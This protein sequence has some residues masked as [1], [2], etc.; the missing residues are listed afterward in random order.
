VTTL[1]PDPTEEQRTRWR[2]KYRRQMDQL[3]TEERRARW[4]AKYLRKVGGE[5]VNQPRPWVDPASHATHCLHCEAPIVP[6]RNDRYR[7]RKYCGTACANRAAGQAR[8]RQLTAPSRTTYRQRSHRIP[9]L[10]MHRRR[11][12]LTRWRRQRRTCAYCPRP[13][14]AIDHVVPLIRGGTNWE[15]NL[16][17]CCRPCNSS[18]SDQYLTEWRARRRQA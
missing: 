15:G 11:I 10:T 2:E 17:P 16:A 14:S 3:T 1:E 4:R 12:L 5:Y 18:K 9:G 8:D 6:T 7:T 13:V